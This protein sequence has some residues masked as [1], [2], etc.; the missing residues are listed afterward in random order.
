M[1]KQLHSSRQINHHQTWWDDEKYHSN[2]YNCNIN[3]SIINYQSIDVQVRP[4][5]IVS[6]VVEESLGFSQHSVY[7]KIWLLCTIF[8]QLKKR[9]KTQSCWREEKKKRVETRGRK[10][11]K[12]NQAEKNFPSYFVISTFSLLFFFVSFF[13]A[14]SQE[15]RGKK[16]KTHFVEEAKKVKVDSASV[17]QPKSILRRRASIS[18]RT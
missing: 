8:K 4:Q 2:N 3:N 14:D 6:V 15:T 16:K 10:R 12:C 13:R 5:N 9:K 17:V 18:R 11:T 7:M 1:K